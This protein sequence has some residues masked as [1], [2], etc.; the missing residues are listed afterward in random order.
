MKV[1]KQIVCVLALA[2][3]CFVV[4]S[5]IFLVAVT[6]VDYRAEISAECDAELLPLVLAL[7]KA[8]SGFN[9]GAKS[10]KGAVG[11]MQLLPS[12]ANYV[13]HEMFGQTDILTEN[14][15]YDVKLNIQLGV[16]YIKYLLQ[17]F[18]EKWAICAYNAGEGVVSDW[19]KN[20]GTI[21]Y[22]ETDRYLKRVNFYK[23]VYTRVGT[24]QK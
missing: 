9:A 7:I 3:V 21:R 11:L 24:R 12:T 14:D 13:W 2:L 18:D 22:A 17:K 20:G 1:R 8:E 15:L 19:I 16:C 10:A 23:T 6:T 4:A 5:S